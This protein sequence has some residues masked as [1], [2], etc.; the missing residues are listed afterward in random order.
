MNLLGAQDTS[1]SQ[2]PTAPATDA[3]TIAT[4]TATPIAAPTTAATDAAAAA[5]AT[6]YNN[7]ELVSTDQILKRKKNLLWAQTMP[8]ALF[9]LFSS[10]LSFLLFKILTTSKFIS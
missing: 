8:D 1:V 4:A 5:A 6:M 2:A 3:T 10:L 7:Y 9:G